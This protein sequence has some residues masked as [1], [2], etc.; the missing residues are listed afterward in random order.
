M[1]RPHCFV[2]PKD[3]YGSIYSNLVW[4][5]WYGL[6]WLDMNAFAQAPATTLLFP[7]TKNI[8]ALTKQMLMDQPSFAKSNSVFGRYATSTIP[9]MAGLQHPP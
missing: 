4:I 5:N 3:S 7:I 6:T 2:Q 8:I 1:K 9:K